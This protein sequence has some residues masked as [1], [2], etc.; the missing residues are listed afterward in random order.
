MIQAVR[1]C[2]YCVVQVEQN[3]VQ[4]ALCRNCEEELR[5]LYSVFLFIINCAFGIM[6]EEKYNLRLQKV[7]MIESRRGADV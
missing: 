6:F 3:L 7:L 4:F 5:C 1:S 2:C